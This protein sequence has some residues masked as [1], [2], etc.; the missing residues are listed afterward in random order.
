MELLTQTV[1]WLNGA[2]GLGFSGHGWIAFIAGIIGV[3]ALNIGLMWLTVRSNRS[4]HD[5]LSD[6]AGRMAMP[7]PLKPSSKSEDGDTRRD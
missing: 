1:D 5:E 6:A 4:G 7:P 3:T 2:S